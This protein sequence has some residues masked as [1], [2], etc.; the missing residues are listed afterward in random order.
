MNMERRN[1]LSAVASS[2]LLNI[3]SFDRIL[4][5]DAEAEVGIKADSKK[6]SWRLLKYKKDGNQLERSVQIYLDEEQWFDIVR[7]EV[8]DLGFDSHCVFDINNTSLTYISYATDKEPQT[9]LYQIEPGLTMISVK[10]FHNHYTVAG[11]Q[12]ET[13][14]AVKDKL[15]EIRPD[16]RGDW[17]L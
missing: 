9:L 12:F 10:E 6:H 8:V 15:R 7:G 2:P 17:A 5:T 4:S 16:K 3:I 13:R 11:E 1:F 14:E